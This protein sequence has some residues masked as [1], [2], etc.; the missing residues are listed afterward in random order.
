MI[1]EELRTQTKCDDD[2]M[3]KS[4]LQDIHLESDR[5]ILQDIGDSE[6]LNE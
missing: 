1:I 5:L 2:S 6:E 4:S 3:I